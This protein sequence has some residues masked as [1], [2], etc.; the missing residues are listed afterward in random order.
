MTRRRPV[1]QRSRCRCPRLPSRRS[2]PTPAS[3]THD[4][5]S[6]ARPPGCCDFTDAAAPRWDGCCAARSRPAPEGMLARRLTDAGL[7]HPRAAAVDRAARRHGDH[8]GPRPRRLLDR[9]LTA[10]GRRIRSWSSTTARPT[11]PASPR[12]PPRTAHALIAPRRQRRAGR[13]PATPAWRSRHRVRRVPRQRLRRPTRL[14]RRARRAP[15]RS[16]GRRGRA[17]RSSPRRRPRP[18]ATPRCAAPGPRRRR[19]ARVAPVRPGVLRA[20]ARCWSL[21]AALLASTPVGGVRPDAARAARTSTWSGGCIERGLAGPL[22][23]ERARCRTRNRRT[24]PALL[25]PAVPLRHVR[26]RRSGGA[27]RRGG[28]AACSHPWPARDRGRRARPPARAR[29]AAAF[30]GAWCSH[31]HARCARADVPRAGL[32]PRHRR[33]ASG[34]PGSASAATAPSSPR[35]CCSPRAAARAARRRLGGGRLSLLLGPPLTDWCA[36]ATAAR[37]GPL[38]ARRTSPTTSPTAPASAP[39]A[40]GRARAPLPAPSSATAH[41]TV[42]ETRRRR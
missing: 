3:S 5:C 26:R 23:P 20:D 40:C 12:S 22:R 33:A 32:T 10:S 37:P 2:T 7:A 17:A 39:A 15:R 35:R 14:D 8:P 29:A 31:A 36:G 38:H 34:R 30:A 24:W 28:A 19:P 13:P 1:R 18:D 4:A 41:P 25:A 42:T 21:A 11:E 6:A 9:C 16:A 27:T